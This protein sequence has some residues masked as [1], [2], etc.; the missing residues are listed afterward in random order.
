MRAQTPAQSSNRR[1]LSCFLAPSAVLCDL[2]LQIPSFL[3]GHSWTL[4]TVP[5]WEIRE[6]YLETIFI[7]TSFSTHREAVGCAISSNH[8]PPLRRSWTLCRTKASNDGGR[9]NAYDSA[10]AQC[11]PG[12]FV[13]WY[14]PLGTSISKMPTCLNPQEIFHEFSLQGLVRGPER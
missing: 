11:C 9:L 13:D 10:P 1:T 2:W 5:S 7:R 4:C 3:P 14:Q 12:Y 6:L 8:F